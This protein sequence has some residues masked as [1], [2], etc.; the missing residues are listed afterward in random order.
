MYSVLRPCGPLHAA[1][2]GQVSIRGQ[3]SATRGRRLGRID[4]P[5]KK[6]TQTQSRSSP[7]FSC[8]PRGQIV[9]HEG[10]LSAQLP[11][12]PAWSSPHPALP[13]RRLPLRRSWLRWCAVLRVCLGLPLSPPSAARV[14][15]IDDEALLFRRRPL[16]G[17]STTACGS[18]PRLWRWPF[19][20][21]TR[22]L[23]R[24]VRKLTLTPLS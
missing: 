18:L 17:S 3:S 19:R 6:K 10:K 22:P 14:I 11:C 24:S 15:A 5:K 4:G 20:P 7:V 12:S 21:G 9:C 23:S 13:V 2:V 1:A 8:L 16:I